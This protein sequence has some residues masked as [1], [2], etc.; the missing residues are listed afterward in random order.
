MK[1]QSFYS[2]HKSRLQNIWLIPAI[3]V[4]I[5]IG[6]LIAKDGIAIGVM[7]LALPFAVGFFVMVFFRPRIGIIGFLIY[8]FIMPYIGKHVAGLQVGLGIEAIL[9]TTLF[10]VIFFQTNR[11]R[12]R[13][14]NN[15]LVWMSIAWMILTFL[16]IG[17]PER[18]SILGW[19]YEMRSST[20]YWVLTVV[21]SFLL[22]NKKS[23]INMFLNIV[24]ILSLLGALYGMKQLYFG[25]DEAEHKWLEEGGKKTH[26]L[27]GKLRI[28]S[29]YF[30]A[31]QFGASQGHLAIVSI[32]LATGPYSVLKKAWYG[33]AGLLIFY[34]MLISGTRGALFAVVGGGLMFLILIKQT[35]ILIVG[36]IVG[37]GFIGV[38]KYTTIG[39]GNAEIVRLRSSLD[40]KDPSLQA[41]LINQ[42]ILRNYISTKPFGAGVGTMGQ[43]GTKF[44]ADKFISQIPPDSLYVK[45]WG[46]YGIVGFLLWFGIMLYT[47]GKSAGIIWLTRD[48]VLKNQLV[49]LCGGSAGILLCSYGNE[50][51]NTMP[52]SAVVYISWVLIWLSPRWDTPEPKLVEAPKDTKSL[53]EYD[54]SAS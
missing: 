37:F 23:D 46:M 22:L 50:V 47:L 42:E 28:F 18:P 31:A 8:C 35:Q 13:H 19:V 43:W 15:D 27:F 30:D 48:P 4:T 29:Y 11:F 2:S 20:L 10:A 16:Q 39:S 9:F 6:K 7:L 40:P 45:I 44:N 12:K 25:V 53:N 54:F 26:I 14:L 41:R 5:Y 21:L 1:G 32:I 34:G 52:T 33:I 38:L 3:I 24:I 17:N 36:A 49:A 51:L